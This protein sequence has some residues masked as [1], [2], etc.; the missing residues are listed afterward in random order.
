MIRRGRWGLVAQDQ[1]AIA[2]SRQLAIIPFDA[3]T[4]RLCRPASPRQIIA[5]H[6][7]GERPFTGAAFEDGI[8]TLS[9]ERADDLIGL[10]LIDA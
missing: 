7:D 8:L 9:V 5:I 6:L 1:R 3:G 2:D 10:L 4:L